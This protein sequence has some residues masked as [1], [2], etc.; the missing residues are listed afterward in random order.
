MISYSPSYI[1]EDEAWMVIHYL[2]TFT[3]K[4]GTG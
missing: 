3:K 4:A 2:R 1:T